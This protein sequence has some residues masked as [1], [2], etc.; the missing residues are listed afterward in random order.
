MIFFVNRKDWRGP[1]TILE[2]RNR[3]QPCFQ[4]IV[5]SASVLSVEFLTSE[6]WRYHYISFIYDYKRSFKGTDAQES[7]DG[8]TKVEL[9]L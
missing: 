3:V 7:E 4:T 8:S 2:L 6:M 1:R 5:I 9:P